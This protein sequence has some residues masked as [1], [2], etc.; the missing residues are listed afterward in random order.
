MEGVEFFAVAAGQFGFVCASGPTATRTQQCLV[1]L[2]VLLDT[3]I[4]I[5]LESLNSHLA[6]HGWALFIS[7]RSRM[8]PPCMV[9]EGVCRGYGG[10]I[11]HILHMDGS[12]AIPNCRQHTRK[13][14]VKDARSVTECR[15]T[16][17]SYYC[18][19]RAR[20]P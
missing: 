20:S 7:D 1:P 10:Y 12:I 13:M 9:F 17:A 4:E 14:N 6:M 15:A 5:P 3:N 19:A 2:N 16:L 11:T 8:R 18:T